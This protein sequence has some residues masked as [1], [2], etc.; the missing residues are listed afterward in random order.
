MAINNVSWQLTLAMDREDAVALNGLFDRL[1][2]I[3]A[4]LKEHHPSL[5]KD[6]DWLRVRKFAD[7]VG[8]IKKEDDEL[9][10]RIVKILN[11]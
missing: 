3:D 7:K 5:H 9:A 8:K 1:S 6:I 2:E 10:R 4:R 11:G